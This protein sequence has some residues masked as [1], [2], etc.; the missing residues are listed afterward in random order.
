[1]STRESARNE[2]SLPDCLPIPNF[3]T[4]CPAPVSEVAAVD[5]SSLH[6]ES[7]VLAQTEKVAGLVGVD[8]PDSHTESLAHTQPEQ[9]M[10]AEETSELDSARKHHPSDLESIGINLQTESGEFLQLGA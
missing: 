6:Q 3:E 8:A 5:T 7:H 9:K 2:R 10:I 4:H 1:M